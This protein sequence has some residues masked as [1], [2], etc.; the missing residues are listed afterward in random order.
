M[1][2][3]GLLG[4]PSC[5][6]PLAGLVT[7]TPNCGARAAL[8]A[9]PLRSQSPAQQRYKVNVALY[10]LAP[11]SASLRS[12][13]SWSCQHGAYAEPCFTPPVELPQHERS[14]TMSLFYHDV[15]HS[16]AARHSTQCS[17]HTRHV[18]S[19]CTLANGM[20]LTFCSHET[21]TRYSF[22]K[23]SYSH[24]LAHALRHRHTG[25]VLGVRRVVLP[26]SIPFRNRLHLP[27]S[28]AH[29]SI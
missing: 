5:A 11:A 3:L 6:E 4:A 29:D 28:C 18:R 7:L 23:C 13:G 2:D 24:M 16:R 8:A 10:L 25:V 22:M 19:T 12:L 20:A 27:V 17:T 14:M 9:Q 15:V 21:P 1:C 26:C